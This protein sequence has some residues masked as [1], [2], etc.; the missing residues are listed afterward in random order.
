MNILFKWL[1]TLSFTTNTQV[2][3][4]QKK[5]NGKRIRKYF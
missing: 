3:N 2:P 1:F 4:V 5:M